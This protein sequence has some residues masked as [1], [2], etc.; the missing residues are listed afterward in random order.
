MK[1]YEILAPAGAYEQLRAAV[2]C[3]A[4]AVYLGAGNFNARRN[5]QNFTS[6]NLTEAVKYCHLRNVKVYV[7]LNTLVFDK[8]MSELYETVKDIAESGADAVIV[9]DLAVAKAVKSICPQLPLHASTQ[10][11]VHNVSGALF[12]EKAGFSRIVLARELSLNEIKEIRRNVRAELE[13]FVHGAHCMS[14]SGNCYLSAMLGERSGNRGLCAQGCRLEW[15]NTHGR[16][17]ALS[18]KDMS[19]L[20]NI[21]ELQ[22]LGIESFKIEGRMKRPEY[23]A[24]A[25]SSL[26][27]ALA[28]KEY[29]KE[30]LRSVFSRN[31]F[32]DGY[33]QGNR[34]VNMF[35]F[36]GKDD[37]TSASSVLKNLEALY[38]DDVRPLCVDMTLTLTKDTPME[39]GLSSCGKFVS[40]FGAVPEIPRNAPLAKEIAQR[41]LSKLG[42]TSFHVG[43]IEFNNNDNLTASASALNSLRR[44]GIEKLENAILE[45]ERTVNNVTPEKHSSYY[46]LQRTKLRVRFEKFQQYSEIFENVEFIILPIEEILNN[47]AEIKNISS[48]I[49]AELPQL[50]YPENEQNIFKKLEEIKESGITH[51]ATGNVGGIKLLIDAGFTI[52]GTH[53]LNITNTAALNMY[54]SSGLKDTVLSFEL[55]EKAVKNIGGELPRGTYIY[56]HLPLM[57]MRACPQKSPSGCGNCNGKSYLTDRK[58][59]RFPLICQ[60]KTYSVLHNSVPLYI[61]DKNLSSLDFGVFY[62]T[63]ESAKECADIYNA[64]CENKSIPGPKTNGLFYR[65]LL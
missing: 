24:A 45:N 42:D 7:T 39:L 17:Y 36:R 16:E 35:G 27:N 26:K 63:I 33:L 32:T 4:D 48:K 22:K 12:L 11:A 30:A 1:N 60:Q 3:G 50:I 44:D 6:A 25:V 23:V 57:L 62:F 55:T 61:G 20:D 15:K 53:G 21:D 10:M 29:D 18:L 47:K 65:E 54:A 56:G 40:A 19:Y 49:I 59:I 5:A 34:D 8:E 37:V 46:P 51:G 2:I 52:H 31:G 58:G 38:R 28:G 9:Q 64:Y 43:N 13:V 41:N 14:T